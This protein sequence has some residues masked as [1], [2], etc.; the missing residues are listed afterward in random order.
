MAQALEGKPTKQTTPTQ[1]RDLEAL[2][3]YGTI[4][5]VIKILKET[6]KEPVEADAMAKLLLEVAKKL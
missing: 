5:E 1:D 6:G 2:E 4:L 3:R